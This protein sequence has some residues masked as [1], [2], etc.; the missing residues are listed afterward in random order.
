MKKGL[1]GLNRT[2]IS[3]QEIW[4]FVGISARFFVFG[5]IFFA[6]DF[7][8]LLGH[9]FL[10]GGLG[11]SLGLALGS[12]IGAVCWHIGRENF[13]FFMLAARRRRRVVSELIARGALAAFA[14]GT[15][16]G[17]GHV[18]MKLYCLAVWKHNYGTV[19]VVAG[20]IA[21]QFIV[22]VCWA[23]ITTRLWLRTLP[24]APTFVLA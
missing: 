6:Y 5:I 17:A 2:I 24:S 12:L 22:A 20:L 3:D 1:S 15:L 10:F 21:L 16:S 11:A 23:E 7:T 9:L 4:R 13:Y 18:W 8:F 14:F 19:L